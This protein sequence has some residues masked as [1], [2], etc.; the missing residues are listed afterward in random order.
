MTKIR[1]DYF[2]LCLTSGPAV[3]HRL[4]GALI[5]GGAGV[6]PFD[7]LMM[8]ERAADGEQIIVGRYT[9]DVAKTLGLSMQKIAERLS[10]DVDLEIY[11]EY[12]TDLEL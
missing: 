11:E 1:I 10:I 4:V 5:A 12:S 7:A 3:N 8:A 9:E 2:A 6:D